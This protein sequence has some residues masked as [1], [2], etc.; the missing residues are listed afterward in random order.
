MTVKVI[1]TEI[2]VVLESTAIVEKSTINKLLNP[3]NAD[4]IKAHLADINCE[5]EICLE[6]CNASKLTPHILR[7]TIYKECTAT[8]FT[9]AMETIERN[10]IEFLENVNLRMPEVQP[11]EH[12]DAPPTS[13]Q[14]SDNEKNL[15]AAAQILKD[16]EAIK[17]EDDDAVMIGT[18]STIGFG[19]GIGVISAG[20]LREVLDCFIDKHLQWQP[21][22][23]T[24]KKQ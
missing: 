8:E 21:C 3:V 16:M 14:P 9:K 17:M 18:F 23:N 5:Q 6:K 19:I 15:H 24:G 12:Q 4:K 7:Y 20:F 1:P 2:G 22:R 10:H 13:E 11:I